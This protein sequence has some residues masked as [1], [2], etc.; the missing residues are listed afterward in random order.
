M[1]GSSSLSSP[2][3]SG[4][5]EDVAYGFYL[6]AYTW[7]T[8]DAHVFFL[9]INKNN[10]PSDSWEIVILEEGHVLNISEG[11]TDAS[12]LLFHISMSHRGEEPEG[13]FGERHTWV[14][15]QVPTR[16]KIH[17]WASY[18]TSPT[19]SFHPNRK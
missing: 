16:T 2:L 9:C 11:H 15:I 4:L 10:S 5:L 6:G 14:K 13:C 17:P 18:L 19:F 7:H 1:W 8:V 3:A 12:Q